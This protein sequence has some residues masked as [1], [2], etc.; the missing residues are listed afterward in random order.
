M[1]R[2]MRNLYICNSEVESTF[3]FVDVSVVD[4]FTFGQML[5]TSP[6][7]L[8]LFSCSKQVRMLKRLIYLHPGNGLFYTH[9]QL[10]LLLSTHNLLS[11]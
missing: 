9:G 10:V 4:L 3:Y 8:V 2:Q 1:F 11:I 7:H 6:W 5:F